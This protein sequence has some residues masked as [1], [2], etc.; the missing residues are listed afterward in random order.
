MSIVTK[1]PK[2]ILTDK[3]ENRKA[4]VYYTGLGL[5]SGYTLLYSMPDYKYKS[6][7]SVPEE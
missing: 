7:P 4:E 1:L 3:I 5:K 6:R 2:Y